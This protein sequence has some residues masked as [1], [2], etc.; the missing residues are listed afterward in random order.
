MDYAAKLHE[1][2]S[3][4]AQNYC[5]QQL[6]KIETTRKVCLSRTY[7]KILAASLHKIILKIGVRY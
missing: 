7:S 3:A 4:E 5:E 6:E 2:K 1:E